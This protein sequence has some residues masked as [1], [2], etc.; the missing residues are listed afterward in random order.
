[1]RACRSWLAGLVLVGLA[2][3][4]PAAAQTG[5]G[6]IRVATYNQYLGADLAP[7]VTAPA[8]TLNATLFGVLERI[9]RT[10]SPHADG[11]RP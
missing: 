3:A 10:A 8:E 2:M 6:T 9:A 1:M 11:R 4:V 5:P 7:L